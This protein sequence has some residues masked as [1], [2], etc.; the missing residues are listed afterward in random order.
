ME[1][2]GIPQERAKPEGTYLHRE[3][4]LRE[5]FKEETFHGSVESELNHIIL[6]VA[7]IL[8]RKL[9]WVALKP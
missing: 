3:I 5:T 1:D 9:S 6:W 8:W 7:Q 4:I 2:A